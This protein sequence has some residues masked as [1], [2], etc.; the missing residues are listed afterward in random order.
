MWIVLD[1]SSQELSDQHEVVR[2]F[3]FCWYD[4]GTHAGNG[5]VRY[6]SFIWQLRGRWRS[7]F[8]VRLAVV[9]IALA[10]GEFAKGG[11]LASS[12]IT[13]V[14]TSDVHLGINRG[15]F[16]GATNVE[17]RVVSAAMIETINLISKVALPRDDGL[18]A[19]RILGAIDFVVITGDLTNRQER[20]P[21]RIQ[22]AS[23]SWLQF[24]QI[25]F[26]GL[27]L[28]DRAGQP[29]P[30]LLVPGNH[31]V[32][33]AIGHPNGLLPVTDATALA[34]I[35]NRMMH[36]DTPR[37][38]DTY[39]YATDKI[40]YSRDFGGAHCIFLTVWPDRIARAW[41][42]ADLKTVPE[43][44]PVFLFA[45]DPPR[46]D[47]R[48]FTSPHSDAG[49][50]RRTVFENILGEVYAAASPADES[51]DSAQRA[52][53]AFLRAHRNIVGY[54]HGHSNWHEYYT[55]KGPDKNIELHTFRADSPM[56]GRNSGKDETKL[57]FQVVVYDVTMNRL[58]S[59]EC[60]WNAL[61]E[62]G[63]TLAAIAWG[64]SVT[65]NLSRK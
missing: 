55:W 22:S 3:G 9:I 64:E 38:K 60:L 26:G 50:S 46:V 29:T 53:A 1:G 2:K 33:N 58:T 49:I 52:F 44:T 36:P 12:A 43:T 23:V 51:S 63:G 10:S 34:E 42:T 39:R 31:D 4:I 35:Y 6:A 24:E 54:F 56:K 57:S 32:S 30:L 28:L 11:E 62:K 37:T 25:F 59:R 19:G 18:H 48:H 21:L 65:I 27:K 17:A 41:M 8:S 45:H 15:K 14:F 61:P 7:R 40:Y 47:V 16:R 5:V 20:L 13:F